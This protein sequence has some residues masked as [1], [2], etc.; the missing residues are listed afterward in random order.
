MNGEG[1]SLTVLSEAELWRWNLGPL[2]ETEFQIGNR[3]HK[4]CCGQQKQKNEIVPCAL[5]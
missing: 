4:C 5:G 2:K 1:N 3:E